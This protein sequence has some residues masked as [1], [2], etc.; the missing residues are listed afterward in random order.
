M[1]SIYQIVP[2]SIID[3]VAISS[4]AI[5]SRASSK[6]LNIVLDLNDVLYK[7]VERSAVVQHG[8]TYCDDQ[9]MYSSHIPTLVSPKEVYCCR[10]V[11]KFLQFISDFVARIVIWSSIKRATIE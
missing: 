5:Q 7:C 6:W 2:H 1:F 11:G 3:G 10:R 9:H 8:H 4:L